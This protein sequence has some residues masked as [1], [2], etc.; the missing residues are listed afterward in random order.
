M[1]II[2]CNYPTTRKLA[3]ILTR[4]LIQDT[5]IWDKYSVKYTQLNIQFGR[6]RNIQL[7]PEEE[8]VLVFTKSVG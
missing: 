6:A 1:Y 2:I 7:S 4:S 3:T 8:V 5:P